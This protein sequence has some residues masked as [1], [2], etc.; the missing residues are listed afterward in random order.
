MPD[1]AK[2]IV[3]GGFAIVTFGALLACSR[4]PAPPPPMPTPTVAPRASMRPPTTPLTDEQAGWC[5]MAV[6]FLG[7]VIAGSEPKARSYLEADDPRTVADLRASARLGDVRQAR[8]TVQ[9]CQFSN[10]TAQFDADV[11]ATN[12]AL[13]IRVHLRQ[14]GDTWRVAD[15]AAL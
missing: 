13:T 10:G 4:L 6:D 5:G 11:R 3:A 2:G 1:P 15:V 8:W 7:A 14:S 12:R 9:R